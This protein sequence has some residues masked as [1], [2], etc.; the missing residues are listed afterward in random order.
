MIGSGLK[1]LAS[2]NGMHVAH[3]VAYGSI[4]GYTATLS[5]GAGYKQ[6]VLTT[7]FPS[8]A[9]MDAL[10][11]RVNLVNIQK[12]YRVQNLVFSSNGIVVSFLDNPGTMKKITAF[13]DWFWPLLEEYG[14][15][16]SNVCTR[17]G[18]EVTTGKWFLADGIAFHMHESCCQSYRA[19]TEQKE[20]QAAQEDPGSYGKGLL[21][22][23]LGSALGAVLWA[24]VLNLGY[25]AAVVGYAIGWL[26]EKGYTLL[27]G[28]NGRGKVAI[29]VVAVIFGVVM[30]NLF[31]D[32][33]TLVGMVNSG[34]LY[35]EYGQIPALIF[36]LLMEEPEYLTATLQNIGMGLLF[37]ALGV[38]SL[39]RKAGKETAPTKFVELN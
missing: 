37:A 11:E 31:A 29:L 22:A 2:E 27:K 13:I 3:G 25:V 38:Y 20:T 12:E 14:A 24:V 39:L 8:E 36:A 7:V 28:K 5:E 10:M 6:I 34:E 19:A 15:S 33:W 16:K 35:L 30:G 17:C 32:A 1:K 4:R 21:G 18:T 26:A 9:Q 23:L